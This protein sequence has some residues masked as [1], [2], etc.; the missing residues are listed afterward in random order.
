MKLLKLI[1]GIVV[2]GVVF[3]GFWLFMTGEADKT[4]ANAKETPG[5]FVVDG[6]TTTYIKAA[7]EP[8][9]LN[10]TE[11]GTVQ[12]TPKEK[13]NTVTCLSSDNAVTATYDEVTTK[14]KSSSS[15]NST[16]TS[17]SVKDFSLIVDGESKVNQCSFVMVMNNSVS[18]LVCLP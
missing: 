8:V 17:T 14:K 10:C 9:T 3:G 5:A 4:V 7:G 12:V 13:R 11:S 2:I 6:E 18:K 15:S 1:T 16:K